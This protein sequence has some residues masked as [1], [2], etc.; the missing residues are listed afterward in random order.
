MSEEAVLEAKP[1]YG[2]HRGLLFG[3]SNGGYAD[4]HCV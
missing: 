2:L 3:S 4:L 1:N